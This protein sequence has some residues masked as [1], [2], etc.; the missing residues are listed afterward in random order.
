MTIWR[1]F[2]IVTTGGGAAADIWRVEVRDTVKHLTVHTIAPPQTVIH[3]KM[4]IMLRLR[5]AG[6]GT[7]GW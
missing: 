2:L 1:T 3:P 4:S 6:L 7:A 5:N